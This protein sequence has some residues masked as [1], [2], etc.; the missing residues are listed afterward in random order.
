MLFR[1]SVR[2]VQFANF[3]TSFPVLRI[4]T[5]QQ[6]LA[7]L[8]PDIL[9]LKE[10]DIN[11]K[12]QLSDGDDDFLEGFLSDE[13]DSPIAT[14]PPVTQEVLNR[15]VFFDTGMQKSEAAESETRK[16]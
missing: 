4:N 7:Q 6:L 14:L 3:P 1:I 5:D 2:K 10:D 8:S 15:S 12:L 9:S 11:T 16:S 13:A